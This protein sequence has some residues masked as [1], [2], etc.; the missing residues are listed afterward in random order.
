MIDIEYRATKTGLS[1]RNIPSV[2]E[3]NRVFRW[4]DAPRFGYLQ[5]GGERYGILFVA[6]KGSRGCHLELANCGFE[7][8]DEIS[9]LLAPC[10]KRSQSETF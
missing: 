1:H 2:E 3:I 10:L 9:A 5:A 4:G 7:D 6:R 8:P